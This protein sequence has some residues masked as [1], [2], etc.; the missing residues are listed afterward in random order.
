MPKGVPEPTGYLTPAEKMRRHRLKKKLESRAGDL[1]LAAVV[2]DAAVDSPE[3]WQPE[4]LQ[5]ARVTLECNDYLRDRRYADQVMAYAHFEARLRL[6]R[7]YVASLDPETA[8][9]E[10]TVFEETTE[11]LP[12]S[13]LIRKVA[14]AKKVLAHEAILDDMERTAMAMRKDLGI[15]PSGWARIRDAMERKKGVDI[16]LVYAGYDEEAG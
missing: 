12:S 10:V 16:A 14:Q 2:H 15:T 9:T 7:R 8:R 6:R 3:N 11:G 4:A 1:G 5:I 13:G